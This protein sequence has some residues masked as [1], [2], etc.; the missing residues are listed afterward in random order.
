MGTYRSVRFPGARRMLAQDV[1]DRYGLRRTLMARMVADQPGL[2][3]LLL[4]GD[5]EMDELDLDPRSAAEHPA[6]AVGRVEPDVH[7]LVIIGNLLVHG[8]VQHPRSPMGLSLYVLGGL[9]ARNVA[10]SG[11]ELV[12]RGSVDVVEMF[13]GSGPHGGARLDGGVTAKLLVSDGFPM[14]VGG[15]LAAPVLDTGRTRI[16]VVDGGKV[17][18][19]TGD[20]PPAAVLADEVR[21]DSGGL[22]FGRVQAVLGRRRPVLSAGYLNGATD[23][24]AMRV[25]NQFEDRL[26]DAI[27]HRRYGRA[28]ALL[29][30]ARERGVRDVQHSLQLADALF[31][32]NQATGDRTALG[33]ALELLDDVLGPAPAPAV[34]AAHAEALLQ[35][36]TL[37]YQLHE[38]DTGAFEQ[39][40]RD[41][42]QAAAALPPDRRPAVAALMGPWLLV[43]REYARS[44]PYLRRT[45]AD[46]PEDGAVHGR[47]ARALWMLDQEAEA[48]PHASRSLELNPA[49][50]RMWFVRGKC[51]QVLGQLA[52]ARLDLQTYADLHPD[53]ELTVAALVQIGFEQGQPELA[54][55]RARRFV[56]EYGDIEGA[57]ARFGRLLRARGMHDRA[58]PFFRRAVEQAPDDAATVTDLAVCLEESRS[59]SMGLTTALRSLEVDP[60]GRHLP[61]LRGECWAAL[62]EWDRAV[63]DLARYVDRY[64]D[65][66]RALASLAAARAATG[67][68]PDEVAGLLRQARLNGPDD[69][70]V[71]QV[72]ASTGNPLPDRTRPIRLRPSRSHVER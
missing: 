61:Y 71:A 53:D 44:L 14:L 15:R 18:E 54:V 72:A 41:C 58:V 59:E 28:V 3:L 62:G 55:E 39:A 40:V 4:F 26:N 51:Y 29:R 37:L 65:A 6:S 23:L 10:V 13:C 1:I 50:D 9:R 7:G 17:R 31:R 34:V 64:P 27:A 52:M 35:R 47:L 63:Q 32:A 11:M 2:T 67:A 16:G 60:G 42:D 36:A 43:R 12:V 45:L 22:S 38:H 57:A 49:D 56:D 68:P 20:V 46:D 70:Y 33:E 66:A 21:D 8:S 25:L 30:A 69:R 19:T 24:V 48:V 5:V